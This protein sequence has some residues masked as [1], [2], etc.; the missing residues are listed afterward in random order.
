MFLG[1]EGSDGRLEAA[2]ES[3]VRYC[4]DPRCDSIHRLDT[5]LNAQHIGRRFAQQKE[6]GHTASIAG[7][8]RPEFG[9]LIAGQRA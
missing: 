1:L 9:Q 6:H 4:T 7:Q 8:V 2:R 5:H 3:Q